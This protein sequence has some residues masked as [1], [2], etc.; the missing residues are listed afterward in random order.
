[1]KHFI[2]L[3]LIL[4]IG[5]VSYSA[6]KGE[7]VDV[8]VKGGLTKLP[9]PNLKGRVS[10]EEALKSRRSR[11]SYGSEPLNLGELSQLLWAAQGLTSDWG[12]R[13]AP[14]AGATYPL[15]VYV[16]VGRVEGVEPGVYHYLPES[17]SIEL[18]ASGDVR[19]DLMREALGQEWVGNAPVT[20]VLAAVFERTTGRY[21]SRGVMYV[22]MEAGHAGQNIYLQAESLDLGTVA[23]GA[24][25][26]DGVARVVGLPGNERPLYLYPVGRKSD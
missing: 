20:I 15:E 6:L 2:V 10:V 14:S 18:T 11:R 9:E 21:G 26:E 1:M 3:L 13:T 8:R 25:S 4:F 5:Y 17:H 16:A 19:R 23:I 7:V 22:H 24:F 12:G